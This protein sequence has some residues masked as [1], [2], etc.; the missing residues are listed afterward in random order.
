[1][2]HNLLP[3]LRTEYIEEDRRAQINDWKPAEAHPTNGKLSRTLLTLIEDTNEL[4]VQNVLSESA[5][6]PQKE[7][8]VAHINQVTL[9]D[10][11]L[12]GS[13]LCVAHRGIADVPL[14]G[15][16]KVSRENVDDLKIGIKA[17]LED[18][19]LVLKMLNWMSSS[20]DL[21]VQNKMQLQTFN[22][23]PGHNIVR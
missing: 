18:P 10:L 23:P 6:H 17:Q 14:I 8:N 15:S 4:N 3:P 11:L 5:K 13:P 9:T 12:N 19:V 16:K 22:V 20:A 21:F 7:P 1:M 2:L